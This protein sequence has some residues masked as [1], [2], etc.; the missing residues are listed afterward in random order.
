[1]SIHR[2]TSLLLLAVSLIQR[3]K[4][5]NEDETPILDSISR[6]MLDRPSHLVWIPSIAYEQQKKNEYQQRQ[7]VKDR[8][9]EQQVETT[10]AELH[11]QLMGTVE[12]QRFFVKACVFGLPSYDNLRFYDDFTLSYDNRLKQPVWTI[13]H[14][15]RP[16]F[17]HRYSIR[18]PKWARC[19]ADKSIHK[20]FRSSHRD[21]YNT[22]FS[23][24]HFVAICNH[25]SNQ[26]ATNQSY[27]L[28]N[29]APQTPNLNRGGPWNRLEGYV[30]YLAAR[31]ENTYVVTGTLY[32]PPRGSKELSFPLLGLNRVAVP[33]HYYKV[34][35][36]ETRR[37]DTF[38]EAFAMP[39]S[40]QVDELVALEEFRLDVE[41]N[42]EKLESVAGLKFF[43]LIDKSKL[44]KPTEFQLGYKEAFDPTKRRY[45]PVFP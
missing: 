24:I 13:E 41:H 37:G 29:T 43:E 21:Y 4:C 7:S 35:L 6:M 22:D 27:R 14:L 2:L 40:A 17:R 16:H 19:N 15:T 18:P 20:Q 30:A 12:A 5:A 42:L 26:K 31:A 36:C 38:I 33:T 11:S 3:T 44:T 28:T 25:K 39:N 9:Y 23:F 1:M 8:Q 10:L 45:R 32:K 34:I